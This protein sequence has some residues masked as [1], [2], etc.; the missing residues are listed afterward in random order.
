[1]KLKMIVLCA[2]C[3]AQGAEVRLVGS[4]STL[5][6]PLEDVLIRIIVNGIEAGRAACGE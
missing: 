6:C 3:V 4:N 5:A 2:S 1:M